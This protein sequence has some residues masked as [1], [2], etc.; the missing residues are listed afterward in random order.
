MTRE[1]ETVPVT[2]PVTVPATVAGRCGG[3]SPVGGAEIR[4]ARIYDAPPFGALDD[5]EWDPAR[6]YTVQ[7][8]TW[9]VGGFDAQGDYVVEGWVEGWAVDARGRVRTFRRRC[10]ASRWARRHFPGFTVQHWHT[11]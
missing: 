9:V 1:R 5:E 2:V 8:C 4:F 11:I 3:K 6:C 10:D 7:L